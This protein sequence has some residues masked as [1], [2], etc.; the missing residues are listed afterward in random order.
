M[1]DLLKK[2]N[3]SNIFIKIENKELKVFS[4]NKAINKDLLN[5]IRENKKSL[6]AFL[7]SNDQS[8]F[9]YD[10]YTQIPKSTKKT[11][12]P[13]SSAQKRLWVLSALGKGNL[14]YNISRVYFLNGQIDKDILS[15]AFLSLLVRHESLRTSFKSDSNGEV[16][17]WIVPSKKIGFDLKYLDKTGTKVSTKVISSIV[18][19][20]IQK[21]F[22][23]ST[24]PLMRALLI[25]LNSNEYLLV[26]CMHHIVSDAWSMEIIMNEVTL[27][28]KNLTGGIKA[29]LPKLRIHYK[30]FVQWQLNQI[31][32]DTFK[33]HEEYWKKQFEGELP[34]LEMPTD[35]PRPSVKTYNGNHI[36]I[37]ISKEST[38]AL[39]L[40]AKET[41]TTMFMNLLASLNLVL[42]HYTGQEDIIVGSPIAGRDHVDLENQIGLFVNTLPFRVKFNR[43]DTYL[44]LLKNIK[45]ITLGVY[46]HQIYPLDYLIDELKPNR[47]LSRQQL[48]D[49]M[50]VLQNLSLQNKETIKKGGES[51]NEESEIVVK[52]YEGVTSNTSKFDL[53]IT[54]IDENNE[55][56]AS[57]E[58][59]TDLF[60]GETIKRF[61]QH[62]VNI[63]ES[64]AKSKKIP[65]DE[66]EYL[67][68]K[69][70]H[71]LLHISNGTSFE[72]PLKT[73]I[74]LFENQTNKSPCNV[75]LSYGSNTITYVELNKKANQFA[76]Y[77]IKVHKVKPGDLIGIRMD[78]GIPFVI[79][80][81]GVLKCV[82]AYLPIDQTYPEDHISY[83]LQDSGCS[84]VIDADEYE[85]FEH[86]S[87]NLNI[88]NSDKIC[89]EKDLVCIVY[90]SGST[91]NPKGV[92][93]EN[94]GIVNHLQSKISLLTPS[95]LKIVCHNSEM[96]F[97]GSI[98]QLFTPLILGGE[99]IISTNNELKDLRKL[100]FKAKSRN[101]K[102][103]EVIP[104]QLNEYLF[105]SE[106]LDLKGI[107]ILILTGEKLDTHFVKKCYSLN[108]DLKIFN[109]YGQ[110]ECSD[111]TAYYEIP[112]VFN[113]S[114]VLI[115]KPI[116][117]VSLIVMSQ[118]NK[119][120]PI[121]VVGEICTGGICLA[122]GYI[123]NFD[124]TTEKFVLNPITKKAKIY[125]TGDYG[126]WLSNG[127]LEIIGR[128][129]DQ[130]KIRG[131]RID[132]GLIVDFLLSSK[133]VQEVIVLPRET[134]FGTK[135]LICY[136][137]N[138]KGLSALDLRNSL[139]NKLP[140]YMIPDQFIQVDSFP[141]LKN[142]KI[143]KNSLT[144]SYST[145]IN[146]G[147]E[148]VAPTSPS[149][150]ML[151]EIWCDLLALEK[152]KIG[153]KD[154]FFDIGG[155]SL[156][157]TTLINKIKLHF[158]LKINLIDV[159]QKPSIEEM[160][161][162]IDLLLSLKSIKSEISSND[163]GPREIIKI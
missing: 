160:A 128:R 102:F 110:T 19:M 25:K 115:G 150:I 2:I 106:D 65:I 132:V 35:W 118:T 153:I 69:E 57:I 16:K 125:K 34:I 78:R 15:K 33:K 74:Q 8:S 109:T 144:K 147:F 1:K 99:I 162:E 156:K 17:Q 103:L 93:L 152:T 22:D 48:F 70:K 126:R 159:F 42:Y 138:D 161:K 6:I 86:C 12:H 73:I 155:H 119:I 79:S 43:N 113:E 163:D 49:V 82:A 149:E 75:A 129:D 127:N 37:K 24:G 76:D 71:E 50:L 72:Y 58:Y 46:E 45:N 44:D 148:Y 131:Y 23:L 151:T 68:K 39:K 66:I 21:E 26:Y 62:F 80:I 36:S 158:E 53:T 134:A 124:L 14:A 90:T 123:N 104:S 112:K 77:L 141:L 18:E 101:V 95:N 100:L 121:G 105:H 56:K 63:L 133:I 61:G 142:G 20:E 136:F 145:T 60:S 51:T 83:L 5:E 3:K 9:K 40:L 11:S 116:Q 143:D 29:P 31:N 88:E 85:N 94:L 84:V 98:W 146:S 157:A 108:P 89:T 107:E 120:C 30:D 111:V 28:Y 7:T 13:L 47:D 59:N 4:K 117:N 92:M 114:K 154:N 139:R 97:I 87:F 96:N 41:D 38:A 54:F 135:E 52:G 32:D 64:V 91:G 27:I 55:L 140:A 67:T 122:R 130:I 81:L 137:K 10:F